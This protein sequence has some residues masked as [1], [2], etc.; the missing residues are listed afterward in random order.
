[1]ATP[2]QNSTGTARS[3]A[4]VMAIFR[5]CLDGGR[6]GHGP[7][8]RNP[9]IPPSCLPPAA[10]IVKWKLSWNQGSVRQHPWGGVELSMVQL[11][12]W[13]LHACS[14]SLQ[15]SKISSLVPPSRTSSGVILWSITGALSR[16]NT[17]LSLSRKSQCSNTTAIRTNKPYFL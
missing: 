7:S 14:P 9:A 13:H 2:E 4:T 1:M 8:L 16:V 17:F 5:F 11:L 10:M 6:E 15:G 3:M 12:W